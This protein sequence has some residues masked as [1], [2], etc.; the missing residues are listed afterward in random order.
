MQITV[1]DPSIYLLT[2][3][4]SLHLKHTAIQHTEA[5]DPTTVN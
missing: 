5:E 2:G 4:R 3:R 1:E